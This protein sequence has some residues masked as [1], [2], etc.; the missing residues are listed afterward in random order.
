MPKDL[1]SEYLSKEQS[2]ESEPGEL[3][4]FSVEGGSSWRHTSGNEA[5]VYGGYTWTPGPI[6]RSTITYSSDLEA[7][8][9]TVTVPYISEEVYDYLALNPPRNLWIKVYR[10]HADM[11]PIEIST[12]FIGFVITV[13]FQGKIGIAQC[14]SL[15]YF[16]KQM[17]PTRRFKPTCNNILYDENCGVYAEDYKATGTISNISADGTTLYSSTFVIPPNGYYVMGQLEWNEHVRMI[18]SHIGMS[19]KIR[20]YIPGLGVGDTVNVYAGCNGNLDTCK[21]RFGNFQNFIGFPYIPLDNPT[22]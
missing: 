17:I 12:I 7:N 1:S 9:I 22:V 4:E 13:R 14:A 21:S 10:I 18:V 20:P 2:V 3:F 16:L 8:E 19:V 6:Q 11:N 5:V 15:E